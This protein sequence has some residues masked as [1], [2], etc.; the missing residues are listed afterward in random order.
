MA[1]A[2]FTAGHRMTSSSKGSG[3]IEEMSQRVQGA[4]I[5]DAD[6]DITKFQ[7][8]ALHTAVTSSVYY[9]PQA[10]NSFDRSEIDLGNSA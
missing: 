6:T 8:Q 4:V 1:E 5:Y 2:G 9:S 10:F 3:E 7:Y